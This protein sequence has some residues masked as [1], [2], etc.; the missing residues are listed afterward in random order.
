N[1]NKQLQQSVENV[2]VNNKLEEK[3]QKANLSVYQVKH[4]LSEGY[5]I[6][7][8]K[9]CID[10]LIW[11]TKYQKSTIENKSGY[12][13]NMIIKAHKNEWDFT[14]YDEVLIKETK[15]KTLQIENSQKESENEIKENEVHNAIEEKWQSL[16]KSNREKLINK[17]KH[18]FPNM[19]NFFHENLAKSW[20]G[21]DVEK[22]I[23]L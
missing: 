14:G 9:K 7:I 17:A 18:E 15:R 19:S 10:Y 22:E 23:K 3:I 2:V 4:F 21:I 8:I 13:A 11:I 1:Y 20:I 6:K 12:F 5:N 16:N